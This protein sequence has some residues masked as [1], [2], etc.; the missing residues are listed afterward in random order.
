MQKSHEQSTD[1]LLHLLGA[2][3]FVLVFFILTRTAQDADMWWHLRA[4]REMFE[5]RAILLTD[6]FSYTRA[7]EPWTNAFWLSELL[8]Y[9]LF[10]IGGSFALSLF[11]ALV[12][13]GTFLLIYRRLPGRDRK[14][15]V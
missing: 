13:A 15:V 5:Q 10:R 12:G 11:T 9:M 7:G 2:I 4:G 1:A 3:T 8:L 6:Q 14:S